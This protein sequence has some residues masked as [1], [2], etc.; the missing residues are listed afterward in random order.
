MRDSL[1]PPSCKARVWVIG[2]VPGMTYESIVGD[3]E[4]AIAELQ[5]NDPTFKATITKVEGETFVP[6]VNRGV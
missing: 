5:A 2:L 6:G 1:P 3:M 4:N